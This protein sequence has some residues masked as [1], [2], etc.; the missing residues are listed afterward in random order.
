VYWLVRKRL[1]VG[2]SHPE[3]HPMFLSLSGCVIALLIVQL[4]NKGYTYHYGIL[5]PWADILIGAGIAN[6]ARLFARLDRMSFA[7][8]AFFLV[9][10]LFLGSYFWSSNNTLPPRMTELI[11]M[12]QGAQPNGYIAGDTIAHY[13]T[14]HSNPSDRIFIFGFQPYVYWKTGRQPA[15]KFINTIHFKSSSVPMYER[16]ELLHQL[17]GNPPELFLVEVGD[18]YT[19]QGNTNDDS[20]TTILLR[21]PELEQLLDNRYTP[22]DTLQ[23]TIIYRLRHGPSR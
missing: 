15:T 10:F 11:Q 23:Q 22:E 1:E 12:A 14:I 18:R 16:Q 20:R 21:Y 6:L 17:F 19:S 7:V 8:N 5:L 2:G 4:E 9:I 13:V 3:L